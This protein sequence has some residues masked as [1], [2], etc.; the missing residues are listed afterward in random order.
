MQQFFKEAI[1]QRMFPSRLVG[2][3]LV[4]AS[5]FINILGFTLPLFVMQVLNRYVSHGIDGTLFT[6]AVGALVALGMEFS[7]KQLRLRIMGIIC[8]HADQQVARN[9]FHDLVHIQGDTLLKLPNHKKQYLMQCVESIQSGLSANNLITIFDLPFAVLFVAVLWLLSQPIAIIVV[10]CITFTILLGTLENNLSKVLA[11]KILH[12]KTEKQDVVN[13]VLN[14]DFDTLHIFKA[15]NYLSQ[16]WQRIGD[17]FYPMQKLYQRHQGLIQN[18]TQSLV[19]LQSVFV[20]SVGALFVVRG[21]LNVGA[22][23]SCNILA[24][25]ALQPFMKMTQLSN[26]LSEVE[27]GL[28]AL[29]QLKSVPKIEDAGVQIPEMRG[30]IRF[31]DLGYQFDS[32]PSPLFE[33][34]DV[35][36][37]PGS[38]VI[39]QGDNG[40]GKTTLLKLLAGVISPSRGQ[41]L[42]DGVDLRQ[43]KPSFWSRQ[44]CYLPQ[45]LCFVSG[46]ILDNIVSHVPDLPADSF[47]DLIQL[48]GLRS[49]LDKTKEG[50]AT[51]ITDNGHTLAMGIRRRIAIARAM[52]SQGK[53]ILFD[54]PTDGLDIH[55]QATVYALLNKKKQE[56]ATIFIASHDPNIIKAANYVVNLNEKPTPKI[57]KFSVK[58]QENAGNS[59]D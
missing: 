12:Q 44:I 9:T 41:I 3:E 32:D 42:I 25:K 24:Q 27:S 56:G 35:A 5:F 21:E 31:K 33:Y 54:E 51:K 37:E 43:L 45:E 38:V 16:L 13:S 14:S 17:K 40:A 6:L 48:S 58:S 50:V 7:Y 57:T 15:Q 36:I 34:F 59:N 4:L 11:T 47:S 28:S 39:I 26:Y 46:S 1:I 10:C 18:I 55:G 8:S 19:G 29:G 23:I 49:F 20:I 52:A 2:T 22:L 30:Q 53:I